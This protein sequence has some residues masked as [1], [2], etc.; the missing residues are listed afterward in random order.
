MLIA[1]AM[2]S[3]ATGADSERPRMRDFLGINGHTVQFRPRLYAPVCSL[4]R[5]YHPVSWDLAESTGELPEFPFSKNRVNWESVYGSWSR[6]GF[7]TDVSLMFDSIAP[8]RWHDLKHDSA[9]Y[10]SA[11]AARFGPS[12]KTPLIEAAEIGNEPGNY[13]DDQYVTL[14]G[15]VGPALRHADPR[16]LVATCNLTTGPSTR[17]AKSVTTLLADLAV[18][19]SLDV[20]NI[21]TYAQAEPYPTW[22]RSYPEDGKLTYLSD[23][24][25]LAHW[26]DQHAPGRRIWITEFGYDATT[27]KPDPKTEFARWEGV[28]DLQQAQYLVR[29]ALLFAALPVD[30]AYIYFFDDKDEAKVHASSGITRNFQPKP[31]YYALAHLQ[32]TL[33]SF[34]FSRVLREKAGDVF[35]YEFTSPES[36][37]ERIVVAWSPT[38]SGRT[39]TAD[40]ALTAGSRI[41]RAQQMPVS[42]GAPVDVPI[43]LPGAVPV[44]ESPIYLFV[45]GLPRA[46]NLNVIAP[47]KAS[48]DKVA[49]HARDHFQLDAL[50]TDCFTLADIRAAAEKLLVHLLH[51]GF[52]AV[53]T[54]RLALRQ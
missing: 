38:G 41:T 36:T 7:R 20:L 51:H 12:G 9:A 1:P 29:S 31:S 10:A 44:S 47:H 6:E 53:Q 2:L 35:A 21:H 32:A 5:D 19:P 27:R 49:I 40:L 17:Y 24:M 3:V 15:A 42:E 39:T 43:P 50:G 37:A 33:G 18:L 46:D 23:V 8:A 14:L 45:T 28:S 54:L 16:L 52:G 25:S 13:S 11:F 4:V 48:L 30:R 26:R 34:R 22:R